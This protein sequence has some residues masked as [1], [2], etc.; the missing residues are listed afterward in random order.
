MI[1][2]GINGGFRQGYQDVSACIVKDGKLIAAIEEE[3]LNRIKH[4]AGHLPFLSVIAVLQITKIRFEEIDQIA[5]HGSTWGE[6]V[7]GR[8]EAY[9][10]NHFGSCPTLKRFHHHDCHAASSFFA[11]GFKEALVISLDNSGDGVSLQIMTAK[12]QKLS[13]IQRTLRPDSLGLFYQCITQYC[14][15]V[16]DSDEYKL[17]GLASYGN[18]FKYDF[19]WLIDFVDGTLKLETKYF[20][21]PLPGQASLHQD[22][23][24]FNQAFIEKLGAQKRL[25]KTAIESFYMD[26]A[27]SAQ[28]HLE[29]LVIKIAQFYMGKYE[30]TNLCL[31]G[32]VALN[33]VMNQQL[34]NSTFVEQLYIQPASNDAGISLGAAWLACIDNQIELQKFESIYLGQEY[35]SD[36][37][38]L[39]LKQSK[40]DYQYV[41]FPE[42]IAAQALADNLVL[43][44]FQGRMEFGPRALGNR[45]ILANPGNP[46]MQEIL[47]S[48]IKFRESFRPF[49]PSVLEEDVSLYF[50]GAQKKSP[51]MTITFDVN[52]WG[53]ESLP[54]VVHVDKTARIQSVNIEDNPRFYSLL[55]EL[56]KINGHGVVMNTSFNLSHEPIVCS[57]RDALASF[58]ASGIDLLILGNYLI[59]K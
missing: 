48:K 35:S 11:S 42:K 53:Q 55:T 1:I 50:E 41:D 26:I 28:Q 21:L 15:F 23:M 40:V 12:N 36:E 44:W 24:V 19:S 14:G 6:E 49:C 5:F 29:Q 39:I 31:A 57:P 2:L 43:A 56:K 25:P 30:Q 59:K 9:F 22:E 3:R 20:N 16:K 13:L 10:R 54:S 37:I 46:K 18:R 32:G 7:Q 4:S 51:H 45:S 34:M 17:M 27:A 47:N 58:Y 52:A 8:L 38:E 33:C